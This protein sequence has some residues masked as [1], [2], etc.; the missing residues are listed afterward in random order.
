MGPVT[1]YS[2]VH[3]IPE[4]KVDPAKWSR[5]PSEQVVVHTVQ[6]IEKR[7]ITVIRTENAAEALAVLKNLI[8]PRAEVMNGSSTTLIEIGYE[9]LLQS[10]EMAW[11]DQHG[12]ITA[13]S[14]DIQRA[15][16][17]RK[18]V[19]ADYFLSG[20]NAIAGTGELVSCDRTGSRV[21]AWPYAAGH[22]ILV[23]GINK[24]VPTLPDALQRVREYAYPLEDA[25]AKRAYG[26]GS[27]IGKC[28]ILAN[29]EIERRI[30]L[31]LINDSLGY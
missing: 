1:Q 30:F 4:A 6:N 17:R 15:E 18:S 21:G 27:R 2:A 16:L 10:G 29:E 19:S 9:A 28:V 22:L 20:V 24:I 13:A 26:V 11:V 7:G 12:I 8:P 14:D 3:L 31:I 5:I 25:R 23:S